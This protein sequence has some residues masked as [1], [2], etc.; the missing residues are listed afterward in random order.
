MRLRHLSYDLNTTISIDFFSLNRQK[1]CRI[2]TGS[3]ALLF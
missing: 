2:Y 3:L 1:G